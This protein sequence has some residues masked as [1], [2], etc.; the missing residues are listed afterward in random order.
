VSPPNPQ[1]IPA[2]AINIADIIEENG[3]TIRENNLDIVHDIPI[4]SLV[5][6]KFDK[7]H[8]GGSCEKIHARLWVISH[9]RDCDGTPLYSLSQYKEALFVKGHVKFRGEDDWW[10]NSE[11]TLKIANVIHSGFARDSLTVIEVTKELEDGIGAL[12]WNEN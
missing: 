6:V 10:L 11:N 9:D 3:R 12:N 8:G 2:I 7:W 5:E 4:G 1:T